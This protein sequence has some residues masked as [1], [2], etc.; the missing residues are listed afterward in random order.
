MALADGLFLVLCGLQGL[1]EEKTFEGLP[2]LL[3]SS[4]LVWF[5]TVPFVTEPREQK[6]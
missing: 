4:N 6:G 5:L 3:V 2:L 1:M